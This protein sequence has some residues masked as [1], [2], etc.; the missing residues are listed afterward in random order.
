[1]LA[2]HGTTRTAPNISPRGFSLHRFLVLVKVGNRSVAV[3][4]Q[5]PGRMLP[6]QECGPN[7][8][9][10]ILHLFCLSAPERS[11]PWEYPDAGPLLPAAACRRWPRSICKPHVAA[12]STAWSAC[13][14]P[15]T[16]HHGHP[17]SVLDTAHRSGD[18]GW[19]DWAPPGHGYT[20]I[21]LV[22]RQNHTVW[23]AWCS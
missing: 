7:V 22:C 13:W 10:G 4:L 17:P 11:L 5:V 21:D 9:V 20:L 3:E 19:A 1:M 8:L 2:K 15:L 14:P 23:D 12:P 16:T 18:E 6:R